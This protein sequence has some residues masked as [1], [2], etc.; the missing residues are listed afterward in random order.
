MKFRS[1]FLQATA[2][3]PEPINGS[4]TISFLRVRRYKNSSTI[5]IGYIAG[6]LQPLIVSTAEVSY[7]NAYASLFEIELSLQNRVLSI[8]EDRGGE[9]GVGFALGE[10]LI[11]MLKSSGSPRGDDRD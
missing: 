4:K 2:V 5:F 3:V 9:G 1:S 10:D 6:C 7:P 11:K 8:M